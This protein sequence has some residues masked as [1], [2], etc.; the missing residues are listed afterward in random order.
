MR[1]HANIL[2]TF[3]SQVIWKSNFGNQTTTLIKLFIDII[4]HQLSDKLVNITGVSCACLK[5]VSLNLAG[6]LKETSLK[7]WKGKLRRAEGDLVCLFTWTANQSQ[8]SSEGPPERKKLLSRRKTPLVQNHWNKSSLLQ[9]CR[10]TL[11]PKLTKQK[12]LKC[13]EMTYYLGQALQSICSVSN[14]V[15]LCLLSELLIGI[16]SKAR[17]I[18]S[19]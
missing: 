3:S 7:T 12:T 8:N 5:S 17:W 16:Y 10:E 18:N 9:T 19:K 13:C 4:W 6:L 1:V 15:S 2:F 14:P 11:L